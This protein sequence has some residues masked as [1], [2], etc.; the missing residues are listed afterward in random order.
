MKNLGDEDSFFL[1]SVR[2]NAVEN[3]EHQLSCGPTKMVSFK[4]KIQHLGNTGVN[5]CTASRSKGNS[6]CENCA[7]PQ[8]MSPQKIEVS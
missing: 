2:E 4:N 8:A 6:D 3:E 7:A 1:S 5:T